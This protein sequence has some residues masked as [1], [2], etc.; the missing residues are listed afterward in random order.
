MSFFLL[1]GSISS[2]ALIA[3]ASAMSK[4]QK[5]IFNRELSLAQTYA[6]SSLGWILLPVSLVICLLSGKISTMLSYWI[7]VLTF[8]ALLIG[9]MLSYYPNKIKALAYLL[10]GLAAV[11]IG[12]LLV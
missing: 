9:L 12:F 1:I 5:Q 2:L 7:G 4:H 3:L 10:I 8:A 6:A 11:S